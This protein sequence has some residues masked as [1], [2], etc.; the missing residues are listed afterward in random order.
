MFKE[1]YGE[2]G[3]VDVV[4]ANAGVSEIGKLLEL[5]TQ[6][7]GEPKRPGLKTL[8]INLVGTLYCKHACLLS[9]FPLH[10]KSFFSV[11]F[12]QSF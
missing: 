1:V 10:P 8:E 3:S 5:E 7:D 2:F 12:L 11:I 9:L 4:C 6:E